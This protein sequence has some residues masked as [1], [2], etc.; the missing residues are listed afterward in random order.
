MYYTS[1]LK[2]PPHAAGFSFIKSRIQDINEYN[3]C[4][5]INPKYTIILPAMYGSVQN[6]LLK[7]YMSSKLKNVAVVLIE[8]TEKV[9][10][11]KK[12]KIKKS[13]DIKDFKLFCK[14]NGHKAVVIIKNKPG[15]FSAIYHASDSKKI[16]TWFQTRELKTGE[17]MI[18]EWKDVLPLIGVRDGW[19]DCSDCD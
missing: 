1:D 16:L 2:S 10:H 6:L 18:I 17:K 15:F 19:D 13:N 4:L 7:G 8:V 12:G 5:T 11:R 9:S 14:S 3:F